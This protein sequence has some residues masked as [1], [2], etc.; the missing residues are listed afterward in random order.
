MIC[1]RKK[2][3]PSCSHMLELTISLNKGQVIIN[4]ENFHSILGSGNQ[5]LSLHT[6]P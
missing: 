6:I 4:K 1:N 3:S 2:V 5:G